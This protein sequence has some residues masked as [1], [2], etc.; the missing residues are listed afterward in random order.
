MNPPRALAVLS[1]T[2]IIALALA[3][4]GGSS[5]SSSA[6]SSSISSTSS[7]TSGASAASQGNGGKANPNT[8]YAP[9]V[10]TLNQ[11]YKSS[12]EGA[13]PKSSPPIAKNK[14]IVFVSC[15]QASPGCN[16]PPNEMAI[17]AKD[18][19]WKYRIVD[20]QLNA[21]NGWAN[22]MAEA[23]ALKP[24]MIVTHGISCGDV[25]QSYR[26]AVAAHVPIMALEEADCNDQLVYPND[27]V[28]GGKPLFAAHLEWNPEALT[29][30]E[31]FEQWGELQ[32]DYV[33]DAT[34]GHAKILRTAYSV[35]F[36]PAQEQGQNL[37]LAK[38]KG[39]AVLAND[40]WV[41]ADSVPG[42]PLVQRWT[43]LLTRYPQANADIL[44]FDSTCESSGL[45]HAI[46]AA[47]R[48]NTMVSVAGEG[49]APNLQLIR[50]NG[51]L[52]ADPA[53]SGKQ[54]AWAAVDEMNRYFHGMPMVP[55]GIG[56]Q[57][58]DATHNMPA[59]GQDYTPQ[60]NYQAEYLKLWGVS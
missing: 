25:L 33:I 19:G 34:E 12:E 38:C 28:N 54:E 6:G 2:C 46:A 58:V 36:G 8:V 21:N 51:G 13:L 59:A 9:G 26:N 10:P 57:F 56:F 48:Q 37:E 50:D 30:G 22:A 24:D 7:D 44:N 45:C 23:I 52:N 35:S 32:A 17:I 60:V 14:F 53:H 42:G 49:Y 47:G 11:L 18:I 5:S 41:S 29:A 39:C 20:G 15:G 16:G 3:G 1:T 55:E 43:T 40:P 27:S 4:C 31:F